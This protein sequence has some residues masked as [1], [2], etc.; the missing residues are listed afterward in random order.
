MMAILNVVASAPGKSFSFVE[1]VRLSRVSRATAHGI[2]LA[3]VRDNYLARDEE[4]RFS[5]GP[6]FR[7]IAARVGGTAA[8]AEPQPASIMAEG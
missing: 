3:L 8:V 7:D 6:A 4:K 1:I 5:I 2:L